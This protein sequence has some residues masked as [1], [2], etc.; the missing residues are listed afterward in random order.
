VLIKK[1][2][3]NGTAPGKNQGAVLRVMIKK[4]V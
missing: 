1:R 4:L 3:T 2:K